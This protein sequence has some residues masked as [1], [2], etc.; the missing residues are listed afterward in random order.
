[1]DDGTLK[2]NGIHPPLASGDLWEG[3]WQLSWP[4]LLIMIFNFIVG[5]TDVYVAGLINPEIQATLGFVGEIYFLIIILA[6]AIS[7]GTRA[8]VARAIGAGDTGRAVEVARQSLLFGA[9]TAAL[10]MAVFLFLIDEI[11]ALAGFPAP[12]RDIAKDFLR[13]YSFALAA[14]Y[15]LIISNAVFQASG[16]VRKPLVTMFLVMSLNVTGDFILVFGIGITPAMGYTGIAIATALSVT[17]GMI[18]NLAFLSRKTWH[19]VYALPVRI[20]SG[21]IR[22]IIHVG[23]PAA[24]LQILWNAGSIVL[25]NI[26]GRLGEKS[27]PALA[28]ITNGLRI[29]AVVYLPAFALNMAASVLTGQSLGAGLLKRAEQTG[30]KITFF[31]VGLM[32]AI[33]TIIFIWA[34]QFAS[35]LTTDQDVLKETISYLRFNMLSEPFMA[36]SVILGGSLQGAGDTRSTMWVIAIGMWFVRLPLA[37]VLAHVMSYGATGVWAA[38]LVSMVVQGLLMSIRF[39]QGIWKELKID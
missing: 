4:M 10:I 39:R 18:V 20:S 37:Y 5:L 14:N 21:T 27:V 9:V 36:L 24:L 2:D 33:A 26:L 8:L 3:I 31:G 32:S 1:M 7:M 38:M 30:W 28:A 17:T 15:I 6:N 16:E 25:Y 12:I 13:I 34:G 23:W 29:E 19:G 22:K 11:I 35:F